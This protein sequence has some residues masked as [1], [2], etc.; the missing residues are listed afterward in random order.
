MVSDH[1]IDMKTDRNPTNAGNV[2]TN[3]DLPQLT[4]DECS[5]LSHLEPSEKGLPNSLEVSQNM[6]FIV[7]PNTDYKLTIPF[8]AVT[9]SNQ[10]KSSNRKILQDDVKLKTCHD[11][12]Y[13]YCDLCPFFCTT[14]KRL[15][16][17]IHEVHEDDRRQL[18]IHTDGVH[19]KIKPFLCNFCGYKG[20]TKSSLRMHMRQHTGEKPFSCDSCSYS[21]AD[22]NS[23]RRHKLRHTGVKPYKCV[24]CD[25]ACIQ[26]S[27]YKA[28][29]EKAHNEQ[30]EINGVALVT[31]E[32]PTF[33]GKMLLEDDLTLLETA[34]LVNK[35]IDVT[36]AYALSLALRGE[37][38]NPFFWQSEGILKNW[39][40]N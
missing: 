32:G 11:L 30:R 23:M 21:T 4:H 10:T 14:E 22:H 40:G 5:I 2:W 29:G 9:K 37:A 31:H 33:D 35:W 36:K 24:H 8:N 18:R 39:L 16:E 34:E 3:S 19:K 7:F 13:I 20:S 25:Y 38:L 6:E 12:N 15:S 26:S 27:T 28:E 17:H 1:Q